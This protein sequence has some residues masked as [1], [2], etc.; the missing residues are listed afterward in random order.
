MRKKLKENSQSNFKI[1]FTA[2]RIINL[3]RI[4]HCFLTKIRKKGKMYSNKCIYLSR[5]VPLTFVFR[6]E[7]I[8]F[9][10]ILVF[11]CIQQ[12]PMPI[13]SRENSPG[14]YHTTYGMRTVEHAIKMP[15]PTRKMKTCERFSCFSVCALWCVVAREEKH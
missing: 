7:K 9:L 1:A 14:F 12:S 8:L 5:Q 2:Q 13:Q 6:L 4:N 15:S 3:F 11:P 10:S